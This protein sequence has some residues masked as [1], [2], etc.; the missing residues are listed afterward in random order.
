MSERRR[1]ANFSL[2][3]LKALAAASLLGSTARANEARGTMVDPSAFCRSLTAELAS[4]VDRTPKVASPHRIAMDIR[5]RMLRQVQDGSWTGYISLSSID[6][7]TSGFVAVGSAMA[8]SMGLASDTL[9]ARRI[10]ELKFLPYIQ[11]DQD[12]LIVVDEPSALT[13]ERAKAVT[14]VAQFRKIRLSFVW[15][16]MADQSEEAMRPLQ[17]LFAIAAI[18]GGRV[19]DLRQVN[20]CNLSM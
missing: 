13:P 11:E 19:V 2:I 18:T 6:D 20:A 4:M 7:Q 1:I 5:D 14:T 10:D 8:R 17:G 3:A 16:P 9:I 12:L 15:R